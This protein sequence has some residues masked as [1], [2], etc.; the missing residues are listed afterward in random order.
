MKVKYFLFFIVCFL[1]LI[2]C[3]DHAL[4]D[5]NKAIENKVWF[6]KQVPEFT[7]TIKDSSIPYNLYLNL[8]NTMA[9]PFSNIYVLVH[10]KNPDN[11]KKTYQVKL[12]LANREGLWLGN[13][14][15]SIFNH[16]ARFLKDFSFPHAGIYSFQL[17]Q[18]MR[19]DPLPGIIDVGLRIEPIKND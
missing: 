10:Q 17:E 16:Q 12:I 8:R 11:T 1:G 5:Q 15:G 4:M 9:Y 18:N 14:A 3:S 19:L 7:V 6:N 13:S 2:S